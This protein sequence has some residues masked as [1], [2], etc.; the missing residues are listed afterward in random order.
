MDV[1]DAMTLSYEDFCA[2]YMAPNRPCCCETSRTRGF[3]R[4]GSGVMDE[5]LTLSITRALAPVGSA[6][7]YWAVYD[8]STYLDGIVLR[9]IRWEW[10][11]GGIR[12]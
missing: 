10:R 4:R 1:E 9:S 8:T 3:R 2:R 6:D 12:G 7:T 11:C 5:K